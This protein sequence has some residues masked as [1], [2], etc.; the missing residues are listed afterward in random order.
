MQRLK[1]AAFHLLHMTEDHLPEFPLELE[2]RRGESFFQLAF[3]SKGG[4]SVTLGSEF[5]SPVLEKVKC[6]REIS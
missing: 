1:N 5:T 6:V 2:M 3:D 4:V